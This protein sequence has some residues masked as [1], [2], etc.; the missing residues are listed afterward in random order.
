MSK[1]K[2]SPPLET[3][4]ISEAQAM[5]G[6]SRTALW[7]LIRTYNIEIFPDVLDARVRRVRLDDIKRIL[8]AADKA[9]RGIA[10]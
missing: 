8:D 6:V 2:A 10:A 4:S 3:T 7:R 1:S 5:L 9:R